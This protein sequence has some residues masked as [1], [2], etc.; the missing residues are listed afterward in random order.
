LDGILVMGVVGSMG[1]ICLTASL[2]PRSIRADAGA[3]QEVR[4]HLAVAGFQQEGTSIQA[5][6]ALFD[7]L[8]LALGDQIDLIQ[9]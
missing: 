4:R 8:A 7:L 1:V 5:P 9:H 6:Q 3:E 2:Q